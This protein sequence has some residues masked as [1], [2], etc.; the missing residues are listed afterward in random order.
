MFRLILTLLNP[1]KNGLSQKKNILLDPLKNVG[2]WS[3]CQNA[4]ELL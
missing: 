4:K 2:V 3:L 1:Y